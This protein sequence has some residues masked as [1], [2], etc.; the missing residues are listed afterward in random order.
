MKEIVLDN[1]LKMYPQVPEFSQKNQH[2]L[3][4]GVNPIS[5]LT[6]GS[7]EQQIAPLAA[8]I[9]WEEITGIIG[10]S[11]EGNITQMVPSIGG[12]YT[13]YGV[14]DTTK[15][16]G[17][18]GGAVTS[19]GYP[20]GSSSIN[21]TSC[22]LAIG[23]NF[24]FMSRAAD[25]VVYYTALSPIAWHSFG[26]LSSLGGGA[27]IM[28]PFVD[29]VA[30]SDTTGTSTQNNLVCLI[31]PT[32][33]VPSI[34]STPYLDL[35][36]GFGVLQMRNFND[37]YLAVAFG[38]SVSGSLTTGYPQNY[39]CL[40]DGAANSFNYS[41]KIPGKFID[42]KVVDSVLYVA[43]Q[44]SYNKTCVYQLRGTQLQKVFTTQFTTI[45]S[46]VRSMIP[47][48]LFDFRN[49]LGVNLNSNSDLVRPIMV[50]GNDE[51]GGI[52][53]VHS[54]GRLFDQFV[55]DYNGN[56]LANEY[57][58]GGNSNLYYIPTSNT[59]Q[60]ILYKSQWVPV[61]NLQA[62]DVYY[63]T[64]PVHTHDAIN[65]TLYG[66]G[67]DI[68]TGSSTTVLS[69]ITPTNYLTAKRTRLDVKGF[70]GD[71]VKVQLTTVNDVWQPIIRRVS[72]ITP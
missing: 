43:V 56:L 58:A 62:I 32:S 50:Y 4:S 64:L 1:F 20:S 52:E 68:I 61:K 16:F 10:G 29:H 26:T 70:T 59:Y 65:V 18:T 45:S 12:S 49:Y 71:F 11:L 60:N 51:M 22:C 31:D 39:L 44:V 48:S 14:T 3:I 40:W 34:I 27:H 55:T 38:K 19:L 5:Y 9:D 2:Y 69:S 25:S 46:G 72:L 6:D 17:L 41:M 24:L 7:Q 66:R 53:F 54:S 13:A 57:V 30:I 35:G 47:C 28:E 15:V 42:M 21:T 23:G 8:S 36:L 37:K 33:G 67:E 63:D